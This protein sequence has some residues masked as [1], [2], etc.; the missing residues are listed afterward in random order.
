MLGTEQHSRHKSRI[1][2]LSRYNI[3]SMIDSP[4]EVV[5]FSTTHIHLVLPRSNRNQFILFYSI[6][7]YF[8]LF[9]S[10]LFER[11]FAVAVSN[12]GIFC[13]PKSLSHKAVLTLQRVIL[14][15]VPPRCSGVQY[16]VKE[17]FYDTTTCVLLLLLL[18]FV[19]VSIRTSIFIF[20]AK[21]L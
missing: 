16:I 15:T 9:S 5:G 14:R 13:C 21:S 7:F 10:T 17:R 4:Q 2:N 8:I 1:I 12:P 11:V 3:S 20:D 6:L 18:L 19:S